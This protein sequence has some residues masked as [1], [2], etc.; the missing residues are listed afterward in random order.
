MRRLALLRRQHALHGPHETHE[1][2]V[3][4]LLHN[5]R[6]ALLLGQHALLPQVLAAPPVDPLAL[7]LVQVRGR[8][9][10]HNAPSPHGAHGQQ[11]SGA[12]RQARPGDRNV[13]Q[14]PE[15][16]LNRHVQGQ[17]VGSQRGW[18]L[19]V[20]G[21]VLIAAG[22]RVARLPDR[23]RI[24]RAHPELA[25]NLQPGEHLRHGLQSLALQR[26]ERLVDRLGHEALGV[27]LEPHNPHNAVLGSKV[28]HVLADLAA[29]VVAAL[30][31]RLKGR[32]LGRAQGVLGLVQQLQVLVAAGVLAAG[33]EGAPHGAHHVVPAQRH[34]R[35]PADA[36]QRGRH[37]VYERS[38]RLHPAHRLLQLARK[39]RH[40]GQG[41][42]LAGADLVSV[43]GVVQLVL[44]A[45]GRG[46][47]DVHA[48]GRVDL[49]DE[50]V[51]VHGATSSHQLG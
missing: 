5:R 42:L 6:V 40:G 19:V 50:G 23:S 39:G 9:G 25:V 32:L 37:L 35:L 38:V 14:V 46:V 45:Q 24:R 11:R 1:G 17:L 26:Q 49:G 18:L 8:L 51:L 7:D 13:Q 12:P 27:A 21:L 22:L 31:P 41:A 36:L 47:E 16:V 48:V 44:G 34:G 43:A 2:T 28:L 3:E 33:A 29:D 10:L 15:Q 4:V 20:V 30:V